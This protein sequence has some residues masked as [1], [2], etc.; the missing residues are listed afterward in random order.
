LFLDSARVLETIDKFRTERGK[1][2]APIVERKV[3]VASKSEE[4]EEVKA[5]PKF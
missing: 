2:T 1:I 4:T 3:V 5:P